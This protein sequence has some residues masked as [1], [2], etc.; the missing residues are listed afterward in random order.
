MDYHM[1]KRLR[2]ICGVFILIFSIFW[3]PVNSPAEPGLTENFSF[4]DCDPFRARVRIMDVNAQRAELIA[5]EQT[6][7]VVNWSVGGRHLTT[8][9]M[10][11]DGDP[12]D[13]GSLEQGQWILV[14][15]FK[16]IEGGVIA[17][18]VQ[19]IE[20]LERSNRYGFLDVLPAAD[21]LTRCVTD[22]SADEGERIRP[23]DELRGL[24]ESSFGNQRYVPGGVLMDRTCLH[25]G[26]F[27]L[28]IDRVEAWD[29]LWERGGDGGAL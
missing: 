9:L 15:G 21:L 19:R 24:G 29:R 22:P 18:L 26:R 4:D 28:P 3:L 5:A 12:L 13:L 2:P 27:A 11:A 23:P 25:T 10:D 20:P 14:K 16:H 1:Y 7:Y 6:I 17:S 8:E